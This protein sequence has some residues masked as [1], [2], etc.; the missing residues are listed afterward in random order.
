MTKR[1]DSKWL[2]ATNGI[3]GYIIKPNGKE[4][5][6]LCGHSGVGHPVVCTAH[7]NTKCLNKVLRDEVK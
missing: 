6:A 5:T 4:Y 3:A 2:C 7:G 1:K